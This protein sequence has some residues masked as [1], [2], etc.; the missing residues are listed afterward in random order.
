L[1]TVAEDLKTDLE[2]TSTLWG[3]D[4]PKQLF[5]ARPQYRFK[6][7]TGKWF[8]KLDITDDKI[9]IHL[10]KKSLSVMKQQKGP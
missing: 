10:R 5:D 7:D 3:R 6:G 1:R 9:A 8:K 2:A 4:I